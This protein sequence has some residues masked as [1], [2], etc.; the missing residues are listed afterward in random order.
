LTTQII[1]HFLVSILGWLISAST[2][3]I[4][5]YVIVR[6]LRRP[7]SSSPALRRCLLLVPW[8]AP[9]VGILEFFFFPIPLLAL[10]GISLPYA[11]SAAAGQIASLTVLLIP[12]SPLIPLPLLSR[13]VAV[14][15]HLRT[16]A[17]LS[18]AATTSA[19]HLATFGLGPTILVNVNLLR[20]V[21]AID[22][23]LLTIAIAIV[24][25]IIAGI[26]QFVSW[27]PGPLADHALLPWQA[28]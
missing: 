2:G 5:V 23:W 18:V 12:S 26:L 22:A 20:D 3:L 11:V 15:G 24:I 17:T 27:K 8:R 4:L 14:S 1:D 21:P 6:L 25:D 13:S 7:L 16:L 28:A 19:A 9:V 10:F